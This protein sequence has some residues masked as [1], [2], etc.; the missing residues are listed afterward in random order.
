MFTQLLYQILSF[1]TKIVRLRNTKL[2]LSLADSLPK[3]I[4]G[5]MHRPSIARNQG[6][7]FTF[8]SNAMHSIWMYHMNFSIDCIWI[9]D[10]GKVV[11]LVPN[12]KPCDQML[13]CP[14]YYPKEKARYVLELK[15]GMAKSLGIRAGTNLIS[16]VR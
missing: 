13:S 8:R 14:T 1:K 3:Q 12:M 11:D 16:I 2:E 5:L 7:L 6:M 9:D 10:G 15:A 4:L